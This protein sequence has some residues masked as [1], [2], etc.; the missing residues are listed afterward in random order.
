MYEWRP[1]FPRYFPLLARLRFFLLGNIYFLSREFHPIRSKG[2]RILREGN[3][4]AIKTPREVSTRFI[5]SKLTRIFISLIKSLACLPSSTPT[6]D[7]FPT[8]ILVNSLFSQGRSKRIS[9]SNSNPASLI[10]ER[11]ACR[12]I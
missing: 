2:R 9:N 5:I 12:G 4:D 11:K 1:C 3:R 8:Q 6:R 7:D 10:Y